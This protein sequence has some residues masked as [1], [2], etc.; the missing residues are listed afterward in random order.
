MYT[1]LRRSGQILLLLLTSNISFCD[2]HLFKTYALILRPSKFIMNTV[3]RHKTLISQPMNVGS[4]IF[5][6]PNQAEIFHMT[7]RYP[8]VK[9]VKVTSKGL[10]GTKRLKRWIDYTLQES[11]I[12]SSVHWLVESQFHFPDFWW[13]PRRKVCILNLNRRSEKVIGIMA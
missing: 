2:P 3:L 8:T 11:G 13:V 1:P 12:H 10:L 9:T 4:D 6:A 7:T 5:T